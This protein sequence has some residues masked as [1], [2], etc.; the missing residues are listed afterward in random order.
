M[1]TYSLVTEFACAVC[2]PPAW[3]AIVQ[4]ASPFTVARPLAAAIWILVVL[5]LWE[6]SAF[7]LRR[8]I[9]ERLV[10]PEI[11]ATAVRT[12]TANALLIT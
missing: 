1:R 6:I 4:G 11:A 2:G 9:R 8:A 10:A 5:K 3:L 12:K 7:T